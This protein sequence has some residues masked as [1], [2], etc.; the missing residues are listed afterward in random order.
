MRLKILSAS[1]FFLSNA[2][3]LPAS[4]NAQPQEAGKLAEICVL[5]AKG[6][7][8]YKI[9]LDHLFVQVLTASLP[10]RFSVVENEESCD[11]GRDNNCNGEIDE[12][13]NQAQ[14]IWDAGAD[15][16]KC[17]TEEC[18]DLGDECQEDQ[19]CKTAVDCTL[20]AK[21]LDKDYGALSCLCGEDVTIAQCQR[22][23]DPKDFLGACVDELYFEASFRPQPMIGKRL[24]SKTLSCM[25][26][27]CAAACSENIYNY[28]PPRSR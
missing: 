20:E 23:E 1:I 25:S 4:A 17:M 9:N 2:A 26:L 22:V 3:I 16:D 27:N 13:C 10:D 19:E 24:A 14:A 11:D 12:G 7:G 6:S 21:C 5:N 8:Q 18:S 15:C 28:E